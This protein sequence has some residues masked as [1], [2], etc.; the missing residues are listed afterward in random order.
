MLERQIL[1]G[2]FLNENFF[3]IQIF[4]DTVVF[5]TIPYHTTVA[6]KVGHVET[7]DIE[8]ERLQR[9][10]TES[11]LQNR[12]TE[13][14]PANL[15][16]INFH[17][18]YNEDQIAGLKVYRH[19][20]YHKIL[21][22]PKLQIGPGK[23]RLRGVETTIHTTSTSPYG[24][25]L[26]TDN[27]EYLIAPVLNGRKGFHLIHRIDWINY[28]QSIDSTLAFWGVWPSSNLYQPVRLER[29]VLQ[30]KPGPQSSQP[31]GPQPEPRGPQSSQPEPRGPQSSQP[32]PRGPQS[33]QPEGP[34][35]DQHFVDVTSDM[36]VVSQTESKQSKTNSAPFVVI[37]I[38]C[39]LLLVVFGL[40][41][42]NSVS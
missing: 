13:E 38:V 29:L 2:Y 11:T 12:G 35:Q 34:Q 36:V 25:H 27:G 20:V 30:P 21:G 3:P 5:D 9:F 10:K 37:G 23:Y 41:F 22:P 26:H 18:L 19:K 24:Y 28:C 7:V 17:V 40:F 14:V 1:N 4:D 42:Y 39:F 33:S 16:R 31:E 6:Y 15:R 32:E 8:E